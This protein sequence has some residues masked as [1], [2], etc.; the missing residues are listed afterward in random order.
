MG[1]DKGEGEGWDFFFHLQPEPLFR[2]FCGLVAFKPEPKV[3]CR[4]K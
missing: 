2:P 3:F 1:R 4:L